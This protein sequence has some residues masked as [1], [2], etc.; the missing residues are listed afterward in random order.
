MC[1]KCN[2]R[3]A[4]K[5]DDSAEVFCGPRNIFGSTALAL[6][7]NIGTTQRPDLLWFPRSVVR[8][9]P[10]TGGIYVRQ[11]YIVRNGLSARI[12]PEPTTTN[13]GA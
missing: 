7:L 11:W 6:K 1:K 3:P 4:P 8:I 9:D 2:H 13:A 12:A 5:R 10:Q